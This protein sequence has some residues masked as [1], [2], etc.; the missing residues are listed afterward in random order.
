MAATIHSSSEG[1]RP[2]RAWQ[3]A[4][5]SD[6]VIP[7]AARA[8]FAGGHGPQCPQVTSKASIWKGPTRTVRAETPVASQSEGPTTTVAAGIETRR[9]GASQPSG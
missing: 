9:S 8:T 2:P 6:R 1:N 5:A 3:Y 7:L 4:W